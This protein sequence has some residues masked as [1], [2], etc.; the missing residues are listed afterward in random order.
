[1]LTNHYQNDRQKREELIRTIGEGKI[2]QG[3]IVDRGH[4][5]G[6]ELHIITTTGIIRIY[7][8]NSKKLVTKL[9]ARPN[10]I[11]R[12]YNGNAPEELLE[13]AYEHK[14]LGYNEI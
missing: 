8:Y 13:I 10:Q 4:K 11:K 3:F 2:V 9:I 5:N 1:M 7:N 6:K 12:Y 14:R